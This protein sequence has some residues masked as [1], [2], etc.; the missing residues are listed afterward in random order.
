MKRFFIILFLLKF[1][2]VESQE[3]NFQKYAV[4][5]IIGIIDKR[6][7][8]CLSEIKRAQIDFKR[9][10]IFYYIIPEGYLNSDSN[11]H[12]QILGELLKQKGIQFLTSTEAELSSFW[13]ENNGEKYQLKTNCYCKSSNELLN[14]KYGRNFTKDIEFKADSLYVISRID[15]PFEYPYGVDHYCIIYPNAKDFLD[16]KTTIQKDFFSIFK[17][18]SAFIFS[19]QKRDFMAKSRFIINKDDTISNIDIKV[20]FKNQ[21]NQRFKHYIIERLTQFIKNAYWQAAISSGSKV[22]SY[23]EINFYN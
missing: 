19:E 5:T 12:H 1:L 9:S 17:F 20:E 7:S 23:F 10:E 14:L 6:D 4:N 11:R 2:V 15:I 21:A 18:P 13:S 16:Q 8:H 3:K 22:N